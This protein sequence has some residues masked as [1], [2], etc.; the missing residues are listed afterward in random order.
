LEAKVAQLEK[1]LSAQEK[2]A[3]PVSNAEKS[4]TRGRKAAVKA[5]GEP[6]ESA[7]AVPAEPDQSPAD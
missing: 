1:K 6:A 2:S 3:S 7:N 4:A 5:D